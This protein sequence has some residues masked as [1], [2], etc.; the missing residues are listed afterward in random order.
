LKLVGKKR[1]SALKS[2]PAVAKLVATAYV[3]LRWL[4]N[5]FV[6]FAKFSKWRRQEHENVLIIVDELVALACLVTPKV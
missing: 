3:K 1:I 4:F 2:K 5:G 6:H